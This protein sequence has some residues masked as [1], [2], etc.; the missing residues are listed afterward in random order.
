MPLQRENGRTSLLLHCNVIAVKVAYARLRG[1]ALQN[2][3]LN[4]RAAIKQ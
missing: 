1:G 4:T 3:A 2:Q